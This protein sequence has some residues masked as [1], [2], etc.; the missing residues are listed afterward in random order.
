VRG[1]SS[2]TFRSQPTRGTVNRAPTASPAVLINRS[3][4]TDP[5]PQLG[6][7]EY[8]RRVVASLRSTLPP[9]TRCDTGAAGCATV[10]MMF[11]IFPD[12]PAD[13][14][15]VWLGAAVTAGGLRSASTLSGST[16][17]AATSRRPT[18]L[19][20]RSSSLHAG[21]LL[22]PDPSARP[23]WRKPTVIKGKHVKTL[24]GEQSE[25]P[26]GDEIGN[27]LVSLAC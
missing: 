6:R 14:Q 22:G 18:T 19:R 7:A 20:A 4:S 13:W 12:T 10:A 15:D 24:T 17:E 1:G 23:S 27:K 8:T 16:L 25:Q 2:V 9:G 3:S 21:L 11:K 5:P 26:R